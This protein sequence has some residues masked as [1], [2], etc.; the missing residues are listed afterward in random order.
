MQPA[1]IAAGELHHASSF[2]WQAGGMLRAAMAVLASVL[3]TATA[4]KMRDIYRCGCTK[5]ARIRSLAY[6]NNTAVRIYE[7][8]F[9]F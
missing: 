6:I 2:A 7:A 9:F 1:P 3:S 5:R 4:A 8:L